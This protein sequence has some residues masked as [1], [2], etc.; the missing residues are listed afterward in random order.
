M[1]SP[2][3]V[4]VK[5]FVQANG[6]IDPKSIEVAGGGNDDIL[7]TISRDAV[8]QAYAE[9][10][11]DSMRQA[12][13][14][15]FWDGITFAVPVQI[16]PDAQIVPSSTS[17]P[18]TPPATADTS[19]PAKVAYDSPKIVGAFGID[20]GAPFSPSPETPST[21]ERPYPDYPFE[22]QNPFQDFT[23]YTVEICPISKQVF[24][25]RATSVPF[26]DE[27]EGKEHRDILFRLLAAKY[28][29]KNPEFSGR[30]F[31]SDP[32]NSSVTF[33][34]DHR[35][36]RASLM[37]ASNPVLSVQYLD[38]ELEKQ[39]ARELQQLHDAKVDAEAKQTNPAGL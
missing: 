29:S 18:M 27:D 10:F 15:G 20:L 21:L 2:G 36:V 25:I 3:Q 28:Q 16:A 6:V 39:A 37:G 1:L 13:G 11:T 33:E 22:A 19:N 32:L 35:I 26:K 14:S 38:E 5:Y 31:P 34:H 12:L 8:K 17:T 24:E 30:L 23:V 7:E 9:P 4:H